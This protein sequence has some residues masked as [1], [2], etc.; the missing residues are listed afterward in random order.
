MSHFIFFA[1]V[2][3]ALVALT[4]RAPRQRRSDPEVGPVA[5]RRRADKTRIGRHGPCRPAGW[6]SWPLTQQL[7]RLRAA[8]G[9]DF[10]PVAVARRWR[11]FLR[12]GAMVK[13]L[14]RCTALG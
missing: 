9:V 12:E 3:A 7:E 13:V 8:D 6:H 11:P 4:A 14:D 1:L 5:F 10:R 2:S